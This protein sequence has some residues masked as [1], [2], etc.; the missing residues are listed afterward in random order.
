Q[1]DAIRRE[2]A[3]TLTPLFAAADFRPAWW[4]IATIVEALLGLGELDEA[5]RQLGR[6]TFA[7]VAEWQLEATV[8]QLMQLARL[9]ASPGKN[10]DEDHSPRSRF[11]REHFPRETR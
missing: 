3:D 2:V 9:R 1:A 11:L 8:R 5:A 4:H 7:D 10:V 6:I